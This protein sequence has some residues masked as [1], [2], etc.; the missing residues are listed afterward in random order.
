[1]IARVLGVVVTTIGLLGLITVALTHVEI[2]EGVAAGLVLLTLL[3]A[4][5]L[6][7]SIVGAKNDGALDNASGVAAVLEAAAAIPASARVGVLVTDAEE[8]GLAGA[9]AWSR[10]RVPGIALN[11]DSIDD[12]GQLTA[13]YSTPAPSDLIARLR[14]AAL[15]NGEQ[16]RV[17][18]MIPGVLT[19]HVPLANAGWRTLTLSRGCVRTLGRVHTSRDTLQSMQGTGIA[20][21]ARILARTATE[22]G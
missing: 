16:L 9:R 14:Q 7:L 12:I 20:A 13:M 1:M 4:C 15:D 21:A 19:D 8:L 10:G 11:C 2:Y 22:L 5:P 6:M 18:R 3:G 17:I